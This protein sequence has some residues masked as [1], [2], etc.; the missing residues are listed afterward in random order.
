MTS[1]ESDAR[2]H[3]A[4]SL[5]RAIV[6]GELKPG[7]RGWR[8]R[9]RELTIAALREQVPGHPGGQDWLGL[10]TTARMMR[11]IEQRHSPRRRALIGRWEAT[12]LHPVDPPGEVARVVAPLRWLLVR[13]A[14]EGVADGPTQPV[15]S[16]RAGDV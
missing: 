9:Q 5:E 16:S 11:W 12:L 15:A 2:D 3:V 8:T 10:V 14:G 6:D 13:A 1:E 7:R 4:V